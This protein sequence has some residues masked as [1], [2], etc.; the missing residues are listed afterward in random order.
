MLLLPQSGV[1]LTYF[2]TAITLLKPTDQCCDLLSN[3][4][5]TYFKTAL[6]MLYVDFQ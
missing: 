5:L 4:S 6:L 2:K 1:S 3:V